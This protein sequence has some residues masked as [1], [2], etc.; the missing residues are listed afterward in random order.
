VRRVF[1]I[2]AAL[3]SGL[4]VFLW[5]KPLDI[6][7][8]QHTMIL[9]YDAWGFAEFFY[10]GII[11]WMATVSAAICFL[12]T[13]CPDEEVEHRRENDVANRGVLGHWE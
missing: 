3:S 8:S 1:L 9:G 12:A 11:R 4:A 10:N 13:L 6:P 7:Q 2:V 5:L